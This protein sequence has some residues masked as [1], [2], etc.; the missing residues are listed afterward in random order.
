MKGKRLN[1][2]IR[3]KSLKK[4]EMKRKNPEKRNKKVA[5]QAE[6][7]KAYLSN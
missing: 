5:T 1:W 4:V 2:K 7:K 6:M 3:M